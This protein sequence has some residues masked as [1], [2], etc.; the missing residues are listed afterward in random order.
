[1]KRA[2][3]SLDCEGTA[4]AVPSAKGRGRAG[5]RP[6]TKK[7]SPLQPPR[8]RW[9]VYV[10]RCRDDTYY[11]GITTELQRRIDQHNRG[12]GARYTRGRGPVVL[13]K[14]WRAASH[15]A[16]L[17]AEWKFKALSRAEK[18]ARLRKRR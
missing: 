14:S 15:S 4:P 8:V 3:P 17:K 18:E 11:C 12:Q 1:M 16:A 7:R 13:V 5:V 6:G 2:A 10:L 9:Q